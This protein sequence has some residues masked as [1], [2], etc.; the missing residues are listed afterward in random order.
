MGTKRDKKKK[1]SKQ[2]KKYGAYETVADTEPIIQDEEALIESL[3]C[4]TS[5]MER[6]SHVSK[7]Q[8]QVD[9]ETCCDECAKY[10]DKNFEQGAC[11][12]NDNIS[13]LYNN[14]KT[15]LKKKKKSKIKQVSHT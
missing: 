12:H 7:H 5:S 4:L 10:R 15:S 3:E 2:K 1:K 6:L 9:V 14:E 13:P 8:Q 11:L